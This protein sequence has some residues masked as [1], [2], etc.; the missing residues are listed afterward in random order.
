[1]CAMQLLRQGTPGLALP[2]RQRC[3]TYQHLHHV[4]QQKLLQQTTTSAEAWPMP[5][6]H[7]PASHRRGYGAHCNTKVHLQANQ[8]YE[9]TCVTLVL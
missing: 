7:E 1:M 8:L 5:N 6:L 4:V 9:T 3:C 2:L